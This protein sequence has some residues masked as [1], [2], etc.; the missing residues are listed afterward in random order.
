MGRYL[1]GRLHHSPGRTVAL[2]LA[3]LVATASFVV[4]TGAAPHYPVADGGHG[5][6]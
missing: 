3:V 1:W 2:L 4:L 6:A 5:G